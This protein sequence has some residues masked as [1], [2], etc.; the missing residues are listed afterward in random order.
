[1]NV[2]FTGREWEDYVDDISD[3]IQH[4][5]DIG[6]INGGFTYNEEKLLWEIIED[7]PGEYLDWLHELAESEEE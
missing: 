4:F 7:Y 3:V 6:I 2:Q 1:M 5:V